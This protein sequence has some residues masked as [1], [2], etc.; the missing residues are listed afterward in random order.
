[1]P[2]NNFPFLQGGGE[3]GELTRTFDWSTTSIGA[4]DQWPQ[5]LR[6]MVSVIL[7]SRFPMFL[8]W[9]EQLI[10]FYNDAYRP[11]LG[12]EG[13]HPTA[14]GQSGEACWPEIWPLIKPLIDQ[15]LAGG[16][17]TWS[18]DQ[19]IPIYRNERL[20]NVYW[21]FSYSPVKD[22]TG[23]I[24]GVLVT[25]V[26]TTDKVL[27]LQRLQ[28]SNRFSD[29][30]F[31]NSVAAQSVVVG[32]EMI[33]SLVN[34][35]MLELWGRDRSIL[36]R[37][38]ME[39]LPELMDTP[40]P[41][42]LLQ[43][44]STGEA[45]S[46]PEERFDLIRYGQPYTGYYRY[47]YEPLYKG[48]N[49]IYGVVCTTIEI[50]Q[51]IAARKKAEESELQSRSLVE[52]SPIRTTLLTGEA[53]LI[54]R[55][56]EPV[57]K[58]WEKDV[59]VIGKPLL[60]V[61]PE[62]KGQ[63]FPQLLANV[64]TTGKPHSAYEAPVILMRDGAE[65]TNYFDFM[66]QP[67]RTTAGEIYGVLSTAVDV[68]E[69]VKT[70]Q[71]VEASEARLQSAIEMA[72]LGTWSYDLV[73]RRMSYSPRMLNWYGFEDGEVPVE[74]MIAA[75]EPQDQIRHQ[76]IPDHF[77]WTQ[78]GIVDDEH[79]I[80]NRRTGRKYTIHSVGKLMVNEA[81]VA[82]RIEGISRDVTLERNMQ[83]E[84]ESQVQQRTEELETI[85]EEAMATNEELIATGEEVAKA[86]QS[87]E[88]ANLY[89]LRSNQNLEQFAYIASHDLQEPL[90]KIQQFADLLKA[91]Y[92]VST[93]DELVY[94]E[95][96][97]VAASR[98]SLLIKDL[99]AFSRISTSQAN[100]VS[101]SLSKVVNE[102]VETL[103]VALEETK[104]QLVMDKLP[105]VQGDASQLGQLFQNLL[106]N[107]LKFSRQDQAGHSTTPHITIR[108]HELLAADL[109]VSLNPAR[110]AAA[111][112][113]I[114]VADNGIGFDEKYRDR[115]FQVFQRLHGKNEFAG[116]G[117]GLAIVQKVVTNHG[118]AI[119]A[120]S[121]PGQGATFRVY[122]PI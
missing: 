11:S 95:R 77:V 18:E 90:R 32:K 5:S 70:R 53:M 87:L 13:K 14:L 76:L 24:G 9:G 58:S 57:L 81:G 49:E 17:A 34:D 100:Q 93:G 60:A 54:T 40:L 38:L 92:T 102:V 37:P 121:Q 6:T 19:L 16:E 94:L 7:H 56:N 42:R 111:Y 45:Y 1:M 80:I 78:E 104:A 110:H 107:A 30:L 65:N 31:N 117:I 55:A 74:A 69:K 25:C 33:L 64:Y 41:Q 21:T 116:T 83:Y 12:N 88:E 113:C 75:F 52:Q 101:V 51:E 35:K 118:G 66:Y 4:P 106:A 29:R 119:T 26:E 15:V 28:D 62:L 23:A 59:S 86:Y 105:T 3:L 20:E 97:Q 71:Q 47:T 22:E 112:Y 79:T 89:L 8:W 109:P 67:M 48:E 122:L 82:V 99:L 115:I 46:Q 73:T 103:S 120:S 10:Q 68:T 85:N 44:Y 50:T 43:V 63:E 39:A 27:N 72:E 98:M 84:L 2:A 36:G 96:M 91:R 61:L 114:E 108:A